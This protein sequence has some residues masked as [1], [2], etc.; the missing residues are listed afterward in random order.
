MSKKRTQKTHLH[1]VEFIKSLW[2]EQDALIEKYGRSKTV[3]ILLIFDDVVADLNAERK[4]YLKK[5][6]LHGRHSGFSTALCSQQWRSVP[7]PVRMNSTNVIVMLLASSAERK[8][9]SE[10][11]PFDEQEVSLNCR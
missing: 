7:K 4:E 3:P 11:M 2:Q 8:S 9:I 10:E 1:D 6:F 5:V